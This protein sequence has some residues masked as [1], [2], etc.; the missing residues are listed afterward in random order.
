M[1]YR[2]SVI[3]VVMKTTKSFK[4]FLESVFLLQFCETATGTY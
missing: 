2:F 1:W 4:I 3:M